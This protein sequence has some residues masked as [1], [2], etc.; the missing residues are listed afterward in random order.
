MSHEPIAS[1]DF[2]ICWEFRVWI[3]EEG[4]V[5]I[6]RSI[7]KYQPHAFKDEENTY[8]CIVLTVREREA[9]N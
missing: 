8:A 1:V 6:D 3:I 5:N 2:E 7:K 9:A 4:G